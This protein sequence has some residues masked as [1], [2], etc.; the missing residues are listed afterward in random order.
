MYYEKTGKG[1]PLLLIHGLGGSTRSWDPIIQDLAEKREV[2]RIDLPGFGKTPPLHGRT[3]IGTLT[4][5]IID[6]LEHHKLLGIDVVGTS[7]GARLVL[8]LARRGGVVGA[9]ISLDPGGFW[10][11]WEKHAFYSSIKA[12]IGLI[13]L[14]HPR[15][16]QILRKPLGRRLLLLQFSAKPKNLDPEIPIKELNDYV[17]AK[18]F[19]ELLK[20]LVYGEKQQGLP[21]GTLDKPL[22]IGWGKKDYVCLPR[23]AYRALDVFPDA[24]LH[25]FEN[26]G[27]FP[28]WDNPKETVD[29]ILDNT[30]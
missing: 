4:D 24:T 6:F 2:I 8:E 26:C 16:P 23:Q 30:K 12:S 29:L 27:H 9:V 10:Q 17:Q 25:W 13:R 28:H 15:I 14:I 18:S 20:N 5:V 11:G 1:K 22:I 3:S 7:M 21:K 19:D